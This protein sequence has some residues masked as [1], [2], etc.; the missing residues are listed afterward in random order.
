MMALPRPMMLL[1]SGYLGP[2]TRQLFAALKGPGW[3]YR[4]FGILT[5]RLAAGLLGWRSD[6]DIE[7]TIRNL[8][9]V[10]SR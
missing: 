2:E 10:T 3:P 4:A 5:G 9:T 6:C 7:T 1:M 8:F